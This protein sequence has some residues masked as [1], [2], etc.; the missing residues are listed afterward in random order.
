[1]VLESDAAKS[2]SGMGFGAFVSFL[3]FESLLRYPIIMHSPV[4][5]PVDVSVTRAIMRQ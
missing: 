5:K 3:Q 1:M 4:P 2:R